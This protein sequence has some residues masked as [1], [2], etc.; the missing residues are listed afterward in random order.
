MGA[1]ADNNSA[2]TADLLGRATA[3]DSRA[4]DELLARHRERLR[5][6]VDLRLDRRLQAQVN[7]ADVVHD[8]CAEVP[9]RLGEYLR[10]PRL[11][12]FLWLRLVVGERLVALHRQHFGAPTRDA[13]LEVSLYRGALPRASSAALAARLLGKHTA[14]AQALA[15]AERMLR[16]QEAIN[17]LDPVDREVVSLRHFEELTLA[18]AARVLGIGE[19]AAAKRYVGALKHLKDILA[20]LLGGPGGH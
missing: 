10:D 17:T 4:L 3:G 9:A 18:E 12:F 7:A 14:T 5:Q 19:A 8:A 11:P 16:L 13:G 1:L 6:M 15:R 2:H 20:A